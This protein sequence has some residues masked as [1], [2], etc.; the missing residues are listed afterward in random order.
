MKSKSK[1]GNCGQHGLTIIG[2]EEV[3]AVF[4]PGRGEVIDHAEAR[5]RQGGSHRDRSQPRGAIGGR[6]STLRNAD[7]EVSAADQPPTHSSAIGSRR[8]RLYQLHG[9]RARIP[10]E[11]RMVLETGS[12]CE[13]PLPAHYACSHRRDVA[14]PSRCG[15]RRRSDF[16]S[17]PALKATIQCR[18]NAVV[19]GLT[20]PS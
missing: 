17:C 9:S 3:P 15:A 18:G 11:Q 4:G 1:K 12:L 14:T 13:Q 5:H 10:E 2:S 7:L 19:A 8:T 16:G 20:G 6:R